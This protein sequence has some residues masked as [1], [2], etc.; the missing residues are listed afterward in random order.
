M[1]NV[2]NDVVNIDIIATGAPTI[3]ELGDGNDVVRVNF[4]ET[5]RADLPQRRR[6][7]AHAARPARLRHLRDRPRRPGLGADQRVRPVGR[8]RRPGHRRP[9][10]LRHQRRRLL[11]AARQPRR[12][13]GMVAAIEVD[14]NRQPVAG[15]GIERVNYDGDIDGALR[16]L[17]PRRRRHLRARRHARADD[18]LRRR[19][20]RHL[21][22]RPGVRVAARRPRPEQRPRARR[23]TS[24]PPRP[25]AASCRTA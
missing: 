1:T 8:R 24:R 23:T 21:P 11:P 10:D 22:D 12:H 14:E 3:V 25:R 13:A 15:G 20:R 19:G 7:R 5:G 17:R 16:D 4:T 18:D 9:G 2:R 6:R